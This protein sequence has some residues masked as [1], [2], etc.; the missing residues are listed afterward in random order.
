MADQPKFTRPPETNAF[1]QTFLAWIERS[2]AREAARG[3]GELLDDLAR[4]DNLILHNREEPSEDYARRHLDAAA[5]DVRHVLEALRSLSD[6]RDEIDDA[7]AAVAGHD[8]LPLLERVAVKL[9]GT[10]DAGS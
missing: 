8:V 5:A 7:R 4:E 9:E 6:F 1:T 10:F 2:D 3:F